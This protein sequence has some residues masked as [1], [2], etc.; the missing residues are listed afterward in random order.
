MN[1]SKEIRLGFVLLKI[2]SM[3]QKMQNIAKEIGFSD[4]AFIPK[5]DRDNTYGIKY[6]SAKKN[7]FMWTCH[8]CVS[9]NNIRNNT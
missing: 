5:G 1:S 3:T 6:F 7:P 8:T 9:K 2:I 4:T